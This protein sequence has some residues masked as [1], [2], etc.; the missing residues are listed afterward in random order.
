[1]WQQ[2]P[3]FCLILSTIITGSLVVSLDMKVAPVVTVPRGEDAVLSC[4][5][6]HPKQQ[7]YSGKII[8]RW[9]ARESHA[10]PFFSCSIKND[11]MEEPS[12]CSGSGLR[13]S[14]K[15]DP[16]RGELS[17]LI[18]QVHEA[19]NGT[20]F[21]YVELDGWRNYLRKETHLYM[22]ANPQIL[23]LS[24][25]EM[26][27]GSG[28]ATQ[29]LRCEA[30]GH[31][32][33]TISWLSA[34]RS[35]S[36]DQVQTSQVGPFRLVSSVPYQE[37]DVF[38]CR[39]ES[40]LGGAERRYPPGNSL[41]IGL[42]ACGLTVLLLL[43][44]VTGFI[45]YRRNRAPPDTSPVYGNADVVENHRLQRSDCPAEGDVELRPVYSVLSLNTQHTSL[46]N[47]RQHQEKTGVVY[48]PVNLQQ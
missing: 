37:E 44:L 22:T 48:S 26:R 42:T 6:T 36:E 1:M 19:D 35:L 16:R 41:L 17:L 13:Y 2:T 23:N 30:E 40:R 38:T 3:C 18:R 14:L 43:L 46:K 11:S 45:F 24:V 15:G 25:V 21:C 10:L 28:A 39:V 5:F 31:P 9:L 32:L 29:R 4:S 20:Y 27:S 7:D 8:V 12:G 34:S 47:S 33:P